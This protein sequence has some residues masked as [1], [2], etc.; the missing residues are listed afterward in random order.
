MGTPENEGELGHLPPPLDQPVWEKAAVDAAVAQL[1]NIRA[2]A[3]KWAG[4]VGTLLGLFGT[5]A[6]VT[7]TDALAKIP[8]ENTRQILYNILVWAG[9]LAGLSILAAS[10]AATQTFTKS[11]NWNGD[12]LRAKVAGAS[13]PAL[14]ELWISRVTGVAAAALVFIVGATGL[15]SAIAKPAN[16]G[17]SVLVV[18]TDG[19]VRCGV[20]GAGGST[21]DGAK[22]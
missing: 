21:V 19:T 6:V 18:Y 8:N 16:Q 7:G 14:I 17:S 5:V 11:K 4:T 20:L 22:N 13:M 3:E 9:I 10:I 12:A 1:A 15:H 2:A